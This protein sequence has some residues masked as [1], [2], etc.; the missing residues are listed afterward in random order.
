MSRGNGKMYNDK[1]NAPDNYT[2]MNGMTKTFTHID[3]TRKPKLSTYM[4]DENVKKRHI[5][6]KKK[7]AE[8]ILNLPAS[9][10]PKEFED[11]I[12]RDIPNQK[13]LWNEKMVKDEGVPF[14]TLLNLRTLTENRRDLYSQGL[15]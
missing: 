5:E 10:F 14:I 13:I 3:Y 2:D 12:I 7:I 9:L 6:D 8:E 1:Y 4:G 15:L 11:F